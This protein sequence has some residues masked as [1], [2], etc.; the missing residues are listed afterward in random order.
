MRIRKSGTIGLFTLLVLATTALAQS[1]NVEQF[2]MSG[3]KGNGLTQ[4]AI[5]LGVIAHKSGD[6]Q[7]AAKIQGELAEYYNK[8]GDSTRA[9][10]AMQAQA[11][12]LQA[13]AGGAGASAAQSYGSP[14]PM[15]NPPPGQMAAM[16][17]PQQQAPQNY[18]PPAPQNYP[19]PAQQNY[20][21]QLQSPPSPQASAEASY[22]PPDLAAA[23][24]GSQILQ[25]S[26]YYVSKG[27]QHTWAFS[28]DGTI[29]IT[30]QSN[31][32]GEN[33]SSTSRGVY[34]ISSGTLELRRAGAPDDPAVQ[35][36]ARKYAIILLG[37]NGTQGIIVNG[38]QMQVKN[39]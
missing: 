16:S 35:K 15:N 3:M 23:S 6:M 17:G 12:A 11:T 18:S 10:A 13:A 4:W 28:S 20:S 24:T 30:T 36:S 31:A 8:V 29:E 14:A 2:D 19:Q 25:G 39:W 37:P 5:R 33:K 26:F 9:R 7:D 38:T 27:V 32:G 34:S 21:P 22:A 1:A